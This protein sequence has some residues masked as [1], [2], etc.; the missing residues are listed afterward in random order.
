M[1]KLFIGFVIIGLIVVFPAIPVF[2]DPTTLMRLRGTSS[3]ADQTG[4]LA[5]TVQR[6]TYDKSIGDPVGV[7]FDNRRLVWVKTLFSGYISH[8]SLSWLFLTG[9]NPRHHAPDMGLLYIWE[10]PFVLA[11]IFWV[12]RR[13]GKMAYILFCW[14]V[15]APIAASPTTELPHAIRTLVFL[16]TFQLFSAFGLYS[17]YLK[18]RTIRFGI[19]LRALVCICIVGNFIYY[20]HMYFYHMDREY[21][22]YWQYGYREAVAYA[23]AHK[24]LYKHIVVSTKLEQ[25][26][27]FFLFYSRYDPVKYILSGGTASGGFAEVKNRFD[28]YEFRP[29]V[30]EHE[31]RDGNTL[32]IGKPS[33]ITGSGLETITYLNGD[34]AIKIASK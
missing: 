32:Y 20:F 19:I 5:R 25:P 23:Q 15:I 6:L 7:I 26:Y 34:D 13:G 4:L 1:K 2:I 28:V 29:I 27:M 17:F 3:L 11:G 22:Q 24:G 18:A 9:D 10:L 14:F 21:S 30:W 31:N 33:E 12:A 8:Y 16:P